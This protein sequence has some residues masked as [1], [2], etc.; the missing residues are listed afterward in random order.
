LRCNGCSNGKLE[1]GA[2]RTLFRF[3]RGWPQ[4][5]I[6]DAAI[7]LGQGERGEAVMVHAVLKVAR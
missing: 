4:D 6:V 2:D 3:F 7:G 5:A 1:R